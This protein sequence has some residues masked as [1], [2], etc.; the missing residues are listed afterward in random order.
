MADLV[1]TGGLPNPPNFPSQDVGSMQTNTNSIETWVVQDHFGFN[2]ADGSGGY[3]AKVSLQNIPVHLT[4]P[5]IPAGTDGMMYAD[6]IAGISWPWWKWGNVPGQEFQ[7]TGSAA[8]AIPQIAA[9]GYSFLPGGLIIQWGKFLSPNPLATNVPMNIPF[10]NVMLWG[11]GILDDQGNPGASIRVNNLAPNV[12]T[13]T[14]VNMPTI[15]VTSV[16]WM[17][18]GA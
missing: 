14:N 7:I 18:I 4:P 5:A 15:N 17:A 11:S 9:D 8:A 12:L 13:F 6:T 2:T 1:Y 10:P 3:H 16:Y